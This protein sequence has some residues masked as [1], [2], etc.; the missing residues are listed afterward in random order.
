MGNALLNA[1]DDK[2]RRVVDLIDNI[3]DPAVNQAIL[4]PLRA[5]LIALKPVRPLSLT[6]LLFIP[7]DPLIVPGH[8]WRPGETTVPRA[9]IAPMAGIVRRGLG[10]EAEVI[11]KIVAGHGTNAMQA[12]AVA[13][14]ELWSRAAEILAVSRAPA[15]WVEKG[16]RPAVYPLLAR[17]VAA[18][19]RRAVWLEWLARDGATGS[20]QPNDK[21][22]HD[23]LRDIADEP[24]EGYAMIAKL[25]LLRSP[26]AA[27]LLR[28]LVA[29]TRDPTEKSMLQQAVAHGTEGVLAY[30]ESTSGLANE[31]GRGAI[32]SASDEVRRITTLLRE[33]E[34]DVTAV[35]HRPR[36]RAIRGKLDEACQGRFSSGVKEVLVAPLEDASAPVNRAGQTRLEAGARDLRTLETA[37][38]TVGSGDSYDRLLSQASETVREAVQAGTLTPIRG[39]RLVEILSGSD[40]A[41]ALYLT[42]SGA[43]ARGGS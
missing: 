6:R 8:N 2:F 38:R 43:G 20:L 39:I 9:A 16:F 36:L 22:L 11:D 32:A 5:R 30:M 13:G 41:E 27:S 35:R 31:I 17:V 18:V 33:I 19:L 25:V 1:D 34:N 28:Q 40:A 37:G 3:S 29:R 24:A 42:E 21:I 23:I 15:N 4:G 12:V 7:L 14:E 10:H 26:H